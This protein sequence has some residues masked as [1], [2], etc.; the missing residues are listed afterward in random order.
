MTEE[1]RQ[2][3]LQQLDWD[4]HRTKLQLQVYVQIPEAFSNQG[5]EWLNIQINLG[6]DKLR[7]IQRERTQLLGGLPPAKQ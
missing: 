6:L 5:K 2:K 7:E 3:R 1:D 4:E